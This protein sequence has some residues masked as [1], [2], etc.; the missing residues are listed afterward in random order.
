MK[1]EL[2]LGAKTKLREVRRGRVGGGIG[3]KEITLIQR[4]FVF[5]FGKDIENEPQPCF[6]NY[7]ALNHKFAEKLFD[8]KFS[9]HLP[10]F[11]QAGLKIALC[12][13]CYLCAWKN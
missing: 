10:K 8:R 6:P 2:K 3:E 12:K 11:V 9:Q 4:L 7:G 5:N 13:K 1:A